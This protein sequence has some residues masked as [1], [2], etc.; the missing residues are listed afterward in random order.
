ML[1]ATL[2]AT[3]EDLVHQVATAARDTPEGEWI[4]G[5]G[6]HQSKWT[7][8]PSDAVEGTPTHALLSAL[9]AHHPVLLT[10]A[11]G[12]M[13]IVNS[14]ALALA[15]IDR[16]T[17]APEGGEILRDRDG[18][19]TGVLRENAMELVTRVLERQ[20]QQRSPDRVQED[21][22]TAIRLASEECLRH[23]ITSFHDAGS[24]FDLIDTYRR[25]AEHGQLSVRLWVMVSE[26]NDRLAHELHRYRVVGAGGHFLTVRAV[27]RLVDGALGSHGAWL[28]DP[29]DDLPSSHGLNTLSLDELRRTAELALE[30]DCQLCVHAIGDRANREVLD[31]YEDLFARE[32]SRRDMRWRIEHAQ[33]LHPDDI[34]RFGQLG[35][36]AAMQAVHATSDGPFVVARLGQRRARQGAYAWR[37][38]LESGAVIANGTDVP[39]EPIDPLA[40]FHA[41]ITREMASGTPFF[42][43]QCMTRA[44]ALR[45]YTLD[46]AYAAFEEEI[47]GSLTPGKLADLVVLSHDILSIAERDIRDARVV[48]TIVG[49]RVAYARDGDR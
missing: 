28:L 24:P 10:H 12:H 23:G 26:D 25:L 6:W 33:H 4:V 27:K 9:T 37:S 34:P 11:S 42:P 2:A 22:R 44:Q 45:S 38:L 1:D 29:Y 36:I 14:R 40:G 35:V 15:G 48:Y 20:R 5:R 8:P 43:E 16:D 47:K 46:A 31:L 49:G 30:H 32:P 19:P 21:L 13:C 41:S 7:R 18:Q 39:V 17:P 3:W